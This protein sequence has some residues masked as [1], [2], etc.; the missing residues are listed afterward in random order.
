MDPLV[1]GRIEAGLGTRRVGRSVICF[2][3]VG[4]TNDV[5]AD[6]A[7]AGPSDGLVVTAEAQ[8]AGRGR[9][10]R[11]WQSE[12]GANLLLSV[13]L[14][15]P[16]RA[17]PQEALTVSAGLAVA[18]AAEETAGVDCDLKW[19]N[20]VQIQGA[21][22][23]GVLVER[24]PTPPR[25]AYI[26][27]HRLHAP[28]SPPVEAVGQP[29]TCLARHRPQLERT[30]VLQALLRALDRWIGR[31]EGG[32]TDAL[33]RAWQH[34]CVQLHRRV[35]V[36]F[37]GAV[38]EGTVLDIHPLEGLVLSPDRGPIVMLPGTGSTIES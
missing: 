7:R 37:Q 22:V 31:I 26:L 30:A 21:K 5:A 27:G 2:D 18:E 16:R 8:R 13:V 12:P 1:A 32:Q 19:P 6:A 15:D 14:E 17:L 33:R 3:R 10:G 24:R 4:S 38:H 20:D 28:Q 11:Q 36:R 25:A 34:R 23:A 9:M 35:K 29:A